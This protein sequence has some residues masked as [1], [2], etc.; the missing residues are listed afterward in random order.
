MNYT[1]NI[2]LPKQL[3]KAARE[4]VKKG[5][6][7]SLSEVI[8]DALRRLLEPEIP[9][10]PMN[11]RQIT[12]VDQAWKDYKAGKTTPINKIDDLDAL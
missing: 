9:I 11:K 3:A 6:Y 12:L 10:I 2:S 5:Y 4:Q 7:G 1:V 8:R